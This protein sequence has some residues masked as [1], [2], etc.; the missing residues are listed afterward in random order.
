MTSEGGIMFDIEDLRDWAKLD[1]RWYEDA[2]I[3]L[4]A[5]ECQA[6]FVM[7]PVLIAKA[8]AASSARRNPDGVIHITPRQ[9][10][11]AC[12]C[13]VDLTGPAL[14][15]L[16]RQGLISLT[17]EGNKCLSISLVG[18]A[19]WQKPRGSEAD[20]KARYREKKKMIDSRKKTISVPAV[21]QECPTDVPPMSHECPTPVPNVSHRLDKTRL[22]KTP[23]DETPAQAF[24]I[25]QLASSPEQA[26]PAASMYL[27]VAVQEACEIA[28]MTGI[29]AEWWVSSVQKLRQRYAS[30]PDEAFIDALDWIAAEADG[31][32]LQ[33]SRAWAML[34]GS[35]SK[36]SATHKQATQQ[37]AQAQVGADASVL[38]WIEKQIGRSLSSE[39]DDALQRGS[40]SVD[41]FLAEHA[42][43]AVSS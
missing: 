38:Y 43:E 18:F 14:Q 16:E 7:W 6:S 37:A 39:E 34:R 22:D 33:P 24:V 31:S 3:E 28:A 41:A 35:V 32:I 4:A 27:P 13:E 20:R 17:A 2:R 23:L 10:A 40:I 25:E 11:F 36:K 26:E 30:L 1:A 19:R 5:D 21:S 15:A 12:R 29:R 8:K 9:L 42:P